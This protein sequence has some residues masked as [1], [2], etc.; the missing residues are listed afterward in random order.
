MEE[1]IEAIMSEAEKNRTELLYDTLLNQRENLIDMLCE[2][3][4]TIHNLDWDV[5]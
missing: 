5:E 3:E 1:K 2:I 4:E